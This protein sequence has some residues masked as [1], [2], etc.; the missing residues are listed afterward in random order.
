[1]EGLLVSY[2]R[3]IEKIFMQKIII[4]L[5]LLSAYFT[6]TNSAYADNVE[7]VSYPSSCDYFIAN[8]N[9]GY[10]L[11]KWWGGYE[12]SEGDIIFGDIDSNGFKDV[13]FLLKDR[14]SKV[15][16]ED[17]SISEYRAFE[18]YNEHCN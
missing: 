10:Y 7:V 5:I 1:M 6:F 4:V 12:P 13:Y 18:H 2:L 15:Y 8:G 9:R 3:I 17:Y 16:V 14:E 11:F